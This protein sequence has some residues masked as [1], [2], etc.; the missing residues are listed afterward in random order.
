VSVNYGARIYGKNP[1]LDIKLDKCYFCGSNA[2]SSYACNHDVY[3]CISCRHMYR[4]VPSHIP[5]E[6]VKRYFTRIEAG[7]WR[8]N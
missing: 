8:N 7:R 4:D 2:P 5:V 6:Q 1:C 3:A